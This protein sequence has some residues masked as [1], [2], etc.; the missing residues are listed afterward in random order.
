MFD[1]DINELLTPVS[2]DDPCGQ[3]LDYNLEF[4]S[5]EAAAQVGGGESGE[6]PDWPEVD[7]SGVALARQS[8][9]LRV[10]VLI[11]RAWLDQHGFTGL[12][13]ALRLL[14]GYVE[15]HW[16]RIHPRPD[17]DDASD[18]TVRISALSNLCDPDGLLAQLR[19]VPLA[20][21]RVFGTFTFSDIVAAQRAGSEVEPS[22]IPQAFQDSNG[23]WLQAALEGIE[24]CAASVAALDA[25]LRSQ[26]SLTEAVQFEPLS[27]LLQQIQTILDPYRPRAMSSSPVPA[28][29]GPTTAQTTE[30][31][32]R[33]DVI[34]CLD[35][36]CR[37]YRTHEPASPVPVLLTR[38][39]RLVAKDFLGLLM[40]LAPDGAAQFRSIAGGAIE[41]EG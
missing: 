23:A 28:D 14:V 40:D 26:V 8:K 20:R 13:T 22:A 4:L 31:R 24:G 3:A 7:R 38:A 12:Q 1:I 37:W 19:R 33:N 35:L 25:A 18:Q 16:E 34:L 27:G 41:A 11:A 32:D 36:V 2:G 5:L 30:I 29:A 39:R 9:D 10:G 6:V 17:E 15:Q 21:S